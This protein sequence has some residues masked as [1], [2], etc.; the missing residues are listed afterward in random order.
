MVKIQSLSEHQE[1]F[2]YDYFYNS[3]IEVH[4]I[5]IYC[6]CCQELINF[7]CNFQLLDTWGCSEI[8]GAI[9]CN[10]GCDWR[11]YRYMCII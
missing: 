7:N 2:N 8:V 10:D 3:G 6:S 1:T 9:Y 4:I 11:Y 5:I